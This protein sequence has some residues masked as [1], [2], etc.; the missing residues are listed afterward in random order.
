MIRR[1]GGATASLPT[2]DPASSDEPEPP[3]YLAP[4]ATTTN[5]PTVPE[6]S[7]AEG[8]RSPIRVVAGGKPDRAASSSVEILRTIEVVGGAVGR[9]RPV[10]DLIRM[11]R[12]RREAVSVDDVSPST[13]DDLVALKVGCRKLGEGAGPVAD[14][15]ALLG[16]EVS[17]FHDALVRLVGLARSAPL[18]GSWTD[19][20]GATL[21]E[22]LTRV[23]VAMSGFESRMRSEAGLRR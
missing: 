3:R 10:L 13:L 1:D 11:K 17:Q 16:E 21:E 2:S 5:V 20:V 12:V 18:D 8:A 6:P 7:I 22:L 23:G 4:A 9:L 14:K 19:P 15:F